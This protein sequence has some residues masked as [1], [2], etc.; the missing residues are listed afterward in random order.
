M[1]LAS[2]LRKNMRVTKRQL[3]LG[4]LEGSE[5]KNLERGM[6]VLEIGN[7]IKITAGAKSSEYGMKR[8]SSWSWWLSV[9]ECC[10]SEEGCHRQT[11][12]SAFRQLSF[13]PHERGFKWQI[14]C[15]WRGSENCSD[16]VV[17]RT[18]NRILRSRGTWFHSKVEHW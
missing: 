3:W 14:L 17:Q 9:V 11:K 8:L 2:K 1:D 12:F 6:E 18:I 7:R 13:R 4:H 5:K 15:Q 10:P 16:E